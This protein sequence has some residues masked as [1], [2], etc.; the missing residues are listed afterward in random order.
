MKTF[1]QQKETLDNQLKHEEFQQPCAAM[2]K[3]HFKQ[4]PAAS[5]SLRRHT[6]HTREREISK[7]GGKAYEFSKTIVTFQIFYKS[8]F[9]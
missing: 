5:L 6:K 3:G 9:T 7:P 2:F 1:L 4:E 8:L